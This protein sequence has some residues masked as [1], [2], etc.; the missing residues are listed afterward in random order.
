MRKLDEVVLICY[1]III[2][3]I[4]VC[5]TVGSVF[6]INYFLNQLDGFYW[7]TGAGFA[8]IA[9]IIILLIIYRFKED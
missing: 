5:I 1:F 6:L 9:L 4:T 2:I 8:T 7:F 3:N